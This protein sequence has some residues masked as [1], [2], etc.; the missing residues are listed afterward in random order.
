[1]GKNQHVVPYKD[2]FAVKG[3]RNQKATKVVDTQGEAIKIAKNQESE[4]II[5]RTSGKIR[6]RNSYG[7]APLAPKG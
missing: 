1:M 5:H 2:G 4:L 3:V 7:N 6:T